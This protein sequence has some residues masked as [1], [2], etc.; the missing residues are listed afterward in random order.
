MRPDGDLDAARARLLASPAWRRGEGLIRELEEAWQ[1][2]ETPPVRDY[3]RVDGE[4]G[5]ALLVELVHVDLE[6][7]FKS[8]EPPR[9]ESYLAQFPELAA[10]SAALID[11]LRVER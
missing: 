11:L 3:L 8:A 9:V 2:G 4:A 1:R 5:H 10:D 7:R 6:F